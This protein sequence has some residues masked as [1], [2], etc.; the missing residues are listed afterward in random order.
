MPEVPDLRS[1]AAMW[2][3]KRRMQRKKDE[4][5]VPGAL[6]WRE[7]FEAGETLD[8]DDVD[9]HPTLDVSNAFA[10]FKSGQ[11][12]QHKVSVG[13]LVQCERLHR[14]EA[15]DKVV[16]GTV[17]LVGT[18]EFTIIGKP[19]VPYAKVKA[20]V[21]QQTLTGELLSFKYK[22]RRR[23]SRFLRKR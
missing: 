14:R 2:R 18:K 19:T 3:K 21:E 5:S 15:G 17:L 9:E 7:R 8:E 23:Q 6:T 16:F 1:L 22:P 10:V 13:D 11:V 20:T 12:H 4:E